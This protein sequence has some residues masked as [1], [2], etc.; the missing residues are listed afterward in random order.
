M[1]KIFIYSSDIS[2][3]IELITKKV[4]DRDGIHS[5]LPRLRLA[6]VNYLVSSYEVRSFIID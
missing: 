6:L 3:H 1:S 2:A 5:V 4:H